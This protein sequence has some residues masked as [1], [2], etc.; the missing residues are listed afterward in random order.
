MTYNYV[1]L[2]RVIHGCPQK[3]HWPA[4]VALLTYVLL[5]T[6]NTSFDMSNS[7]FF[8]YFAQFFY[9][10]N[11]ANSRA[12][13]PIIIIIICVFE[14]EGKASNYSSKPK[15]GIF[16]ATFPQ[17]TNW[18]APPPPSSWRRLGTTTYLRPT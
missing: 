7:Y 1:V 3:S 4:V 2:R 6:E 8:R 12:R 9:F 13:E 11:L 15:N 18:R 5:P 10:L 16:Y 17:A 14:L